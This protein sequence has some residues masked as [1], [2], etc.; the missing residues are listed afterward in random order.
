MK[1]QLLVYVQQNLLSNSDFPLRTDDDLL[2]SGLVDSLG[3]MQLVAFIEENF[4]LQ[5][6]AEDMT[7]EYFVNIDAICTYLES[8]KIV[9]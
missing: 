8:R 1:D 4:E 3:M 5:V 2:G 9:S 6:P 7:I